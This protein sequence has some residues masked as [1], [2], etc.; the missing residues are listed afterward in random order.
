MNMSHFKICMNY[1]KKK[2]DK[3]CRCESTS[4][5]YDSHDVDCSVNGKAVG[6]LKNTMHCQVF[7]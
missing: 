5:K 4:T 2:Q 3:I 6:I 7:K 1:K